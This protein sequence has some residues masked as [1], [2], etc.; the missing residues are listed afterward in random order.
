MQE[1]AS[2]VESVEVLTEQ[3]QNLEKWMLHLR[4]NEGFP[5]SW[6]QTPFQKARA[7]TLMHQGLLEYH[8][9]DLQRIR[10]TP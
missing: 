10:L 1:G 4:M 6:L 2:V 5:G 3:Q 9:H 8:P 7:E